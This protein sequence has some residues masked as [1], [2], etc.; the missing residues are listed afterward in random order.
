[1]FQGFSLHCLQNFILVD[2][3][4]NLEK[5]CIL[6]FEMKFASILALTQ[7]GFASDNKLNYSKSS[8]PQTVS[9]KTHKN[10]MS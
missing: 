8:I 7:D 6:N 3:L 2:F 4:S 10:R 1:M 9:P 5:F